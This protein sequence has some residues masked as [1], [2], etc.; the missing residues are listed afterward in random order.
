[1]EEILPI[2]TKALILKDGRVIKS[3]H[4]SDVLSD[5][6]IS[7]LYGISVQLVKKQDRYWPVP[8]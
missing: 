5:Q 8:A 1:V 2:F 4:A 3:G 7:E 6:S